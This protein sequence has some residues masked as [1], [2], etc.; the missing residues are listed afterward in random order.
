M[1]I[2]EKYRDLM[3]PDIQ[4][5]PQENIV[6][7]G[8]GGTPLVRAKN[9][10]K[11]LKTQGKD[12]KAQVWLKGE[13]QNPS[14]SFKDR[15]MTTAISFEKN[16]GTR[17]VICASTGNTSA[18]AAKYAKAAGMKC[19][20]ILPEGHIAQGKLLQAYM[21]GATVIQIKGNF[22]N[23]LALVKEVSSKNPDV[24]LV[25]N[26]H[27]Y[28]LCGQETAAYEICEALGRPP[29]HHFLPVGN[30]GN[31]TAY[32]RGYTKYI[33]L[34]KLP[35]FYPKMMGY[36]AA[37][38]APIVLGHVVENPETVASAIRIGNPAR[39]VEAN[40]IRKISDG[41]IDSV[42]DDE[43]LEAYKLIWDMEEIFC[44]PSSATSV[45][46]LI[47]EVRGSGGKSRTYFWEVAVVVC[48]LTGAGQKDPETAFRV[49][50]KDP[51]VLEPQI[52]AVMD[53]IRNK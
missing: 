35:F 36:Q 14:G 28:R 30:A 19:Y 24:V 38:A 48:T 8:E 31:I 4:V 34:K 26:M 16:R 9:L 1:G 53:A 47:K 3:P 21:N 17:A 40:I 22:D 25:N 42:T 12:F 45:A 7:L 10:E 51:I 23:A 27:P 37:G 44:E 50:A 32:W 13:G 33:N 2:I 49:F 46:G 41:R 11:Y 43:I 15:G 39:W 6:T 5:I 52:D 18:S 29:T 20:V